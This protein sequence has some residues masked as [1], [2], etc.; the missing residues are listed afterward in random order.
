VRKTIVLVIALASLVLGSNAFAQSV[1]GANDWEN[2]Q[3]LGINKEPPHATQMI[4]P[5][6]KAAL[7]GDWNES[8]YYK[9]LNGMWK[10]H[11]VRSSD[12]RPID[13][14]K[15][16]YDVG[17]WDKIPVP[18][19]WQ[20][21][22]YGIP[23]YV[24]VGY[25]FKGE[26]PNVAH[27]YSP[28]GS[29]RTEFEVP[30][31]WHERHV[32]IH[33]DGVE[34]AFY[35]WLNGEKVGYSQGSRTPAEF[36]L[37]PYL[38]KGKNV[39]AAE[40]YRWSDGSYLEDQDMW[41]LSGIFRDVY[42]FST[43]PAHIRDFSIRTDLD[44]HYRDAVL[45]VTVKVKNYS[46]SI[47]KGLEVEAT[48][49]DAAG[50]RVG[51]EEL[52]ADGIEY[53]RSDAESIVLLRSQVANPLKWSAEHP[54]LYM[55]LL[56]LR[57]G[58]GDVLEVIPSK[59]GFREVEIKGGQLLVNG[60]PV[61]LKGVNRHEHDPDTGHYVTKETMIK[62]IE[63]MK[64]FNI[65]AVRTSHYANAPQWYDLCD[66]YGIYLT[67]EANN[68]SH[69]AGDYGED[70]LANKPEW[71][72][73]I[74]ERLRRIVER[75]KNHP[76]VIIWS[77]GNEV[78][79]GTNLEAASDWVHQ[80]DPS[81]PVQYDYFW[82]LH[83]DIICPMYISINRLVDYARE[84]RDRP[85]IMC[86]YA[87]SMGNST[88]NLQEFWDVIERYKHLQGGHIWDW[89]DQ[90][91]R[92]YATDKNGK[93]VW[94]WAYGGDYGDEP[95]DGNFCINGLVFPD[96][97]VPPKLW[98][99]KK[100]H[101]YIS[102]EHEN[103]A[104]YRTIE[105]APYTPASVSIRNK[106]FFT[107]LNEFNI[108]WSLSED[109]RV[110]QQGR[111]DPID[112]APGDSRSL[113]VPYEQ[114]KIKPGAEYWMRIGFLLRENKKWARKGHEVAWEQLKIPFDGPSK[115]VMDINEM[116]ELEF[117]DFGELV[118]ISGE[119]CAVVF[120]RKTG[121]IKSLHYGENTVISDGDETVNGPVLNV[122][123][124]PTDNDKFV[125]ESWYDAGLN[126][127]ERE[128]EDF[129]IDR[130]SPKAITVSI[131]TVS[132]SAGNGGFRLRSVYTVL[133]NGCIDVDNSIEPFGDLPRVLPKIGL[134]MTVA[135]AFENFQWY[136]RGPHENYP[137]RKVSADVGQYRST[138]TE[139]YVRYPMPQETG[140]RE[141]VR[142]AALTDR[143][144]AGLLIVAQ[145][146]LAVTALHYT[147]DD[148]DR[149]KHIHELEPREDIH[150]SL[151]YKQCG[152][153]NG[154]VGSD[155]QVLEKYALHPEPVSYRFSLR[156]YTPA[157]GDIA[158]VARLRI[159]DG[160]N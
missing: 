83:T 109:G 19:N 14:Y 61:L 112:V 66:E 21:H 26:L 100:V 13:F 121:T 134:Q 76:S 108:T 135:G 93:E 81:R 136:G 29:Y 49:L 129:R 110:I 156:P 133:G 125:R 113:T 68:E 142:W 2:P 122:F 32:F 103:I 105:P 5:S 4:Y 3:V 74:V 159:A 28:V 92:K 149:A 70:T 104:E 62:D 45:R 25:P 43:P 16:D 1:G 128:V 37:T 127:L 146:I 86:E 8:P 145:D 126:R 139:Q 82:N 80:R 143:S 35:L 111:L 99:V 75:D 57:D 101:Q 132:Q 96:R 53:L 115:P 154:S 10:F 12:D 91:L 60:V 41:R 55:L 131:T 153:G 44:E 155:H 46:D 94:Y 98:E 140:N 51:T 31:D 50:D 15:P 116:S 30:G 11:W 24:N 47:F 34:S 22:G 87:H 36:N 18:S 90:G 52:M 117:D 78:G 9:L 27:E 65:N 23:I 56:T 119:D 114:P 106:Y 39:L 85:L 150:L 88:G 42:L 6:T 20:L 64:Q 160:T 58:A 102:V 130:L 118:E 120:S 151:D 157:M 54:N 97:E 48:L 72:E 95:N 71:K 63:L 158:D 7:K 84:K 79:A 138:V 137:D 77:L 67:N 144:G 124:A 69:G 147:A 152:L 73:A 123:R 33:F 107:N 40:V 89:V 59:I 17:S 38:R 141:D 148:L